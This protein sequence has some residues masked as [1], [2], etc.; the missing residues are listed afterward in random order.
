MLP[1]NLLDDFLDQFPNRIDLLSMPVVWIVLTCLF[2]R[3]LQKALELTRSHHTFDP[4]LVWVCL[5][6][7]VGLGW[8][9]LVVARVSDGLRNWFVTRGDP[10]GDA[11]WPIGLA[12]CVV[13]MAAW[14]SCCIPCLNVGLFLGWLVLMILYWIR[15]HDL[16]KRIEASSF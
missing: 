5:I 7:V 2:L 8:Q 14:L 12:Y 13:G 6:P 15:I 10:Q 11:H 4:R 16:V 1:P 9:F 3:T